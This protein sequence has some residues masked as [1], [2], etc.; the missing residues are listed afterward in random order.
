M[1]Q[2]CFAVLFL[3]VL[4]WSLQHLE[5]VKRGRALSPGLGENSLYIFGGR[6]GPASALAEEIT[7]TLLAREDSPA[8][9]KEP[10]WLG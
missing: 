9:A 8:E 1:L 6:P 10:R 4:A 5:N 7:V 3:L 2:R